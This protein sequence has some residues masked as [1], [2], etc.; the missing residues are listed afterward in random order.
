L[1][2]ESVRQSL[3][4]KIAGLVQPV[5]QSVSQSVMSLASDLPTYPYFT[6]IDH[7]VICFTSIRLPQQIK[8]QLKLDNDTVTIYLTENRVIITDKENPNFIIRQITRN[9]IEC[10]MPLIK[11]DLAQ[12][13][14]AFHTTQSSSPPPS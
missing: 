8:L 5:S 7:N 6:L 4:I 9:I 12:W 3:F 1:N 10:S 14:K 13:L 11:Q 2:N